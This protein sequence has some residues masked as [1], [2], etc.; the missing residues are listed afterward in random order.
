MT[1]SNRL[2][3]Q[4]LQV[5]TLSLAEYVPGLTNAI[6]LEA[7]KAY[8]PEQKS[9]SCLQRPHTRQ[10]AA[11]LLQISLPTL[12][13][14]VQEGR[15]SKIKLGKRLVRISPNSVAALLQS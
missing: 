8:Q 6:L 13:R 12:N 2:P 9:S 3:A 15:L 11:E 14:Y 4:M 7:L 5:A 10:E 1:V